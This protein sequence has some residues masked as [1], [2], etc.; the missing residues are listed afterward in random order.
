MLASTSRGKLQPDR[1]KEALAIIF[2]VKKFHKFIHGINLGC[3]QTTESINNIFQR[4]DYLRR[5]L[6]D[7]NAGVQ[8][9]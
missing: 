3:K 2:A 5:Q 8:S 7:Y 6:T 9:Y 4:R 1:K